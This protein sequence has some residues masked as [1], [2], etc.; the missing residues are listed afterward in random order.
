MENYSKSG[1]IQHSE[2]KNVFG[3]KKNIFGAR[4]REDLI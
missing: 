3:A 1:L 4:N 2:G